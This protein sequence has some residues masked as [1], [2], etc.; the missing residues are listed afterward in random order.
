MKRFIIQSIGIGVLLSLFLVSCERNTQGPVDNSGASPAAALSKAGW[1]QD[2][3]AGVSV[4]ASG[5]NGPRGLKFGHDGYLYVSE[6]GLGGTASSIGCE[7]VIPPVGPYTNGPT[8]RICRISSTGEVS[9]VVDG[10][11]SG[12]NAMG[13]LLGV[14]DVAFIGNR[15]YGLLSG[16]GCSHGRADVPASVIRVG[17]NGDWSVVADLSTY[18]QGNPVAHPEED[19]FEPDGSWYSMITVGDDLFA[20]EPNHG[21]LVK[22]DPE[23]G[24]ITRVADISASQGHI[25][26]TVVVYH[27]GSFYV[28]NLN[29][30]PI[31]PGGS[32]IL[33]ISR[34]GNVEV[35]ATGFT[36]V[37]GL[38]F[39]RGGELYVLESTTSAGF[40]TPNT[41]RVVRVNKSGPNDVIADGLFFPTGMT[42]G[43]DGDLFVSNRGFGPPIPGFGEILR[44]GL[45]HGKGEGED[46]HGEDDEN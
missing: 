5:L 16:G 1:N 17:G 23:T 9:T 46:H 18:Q 7:Q 42:V 10:L 43:P 26:P 40:P 25:V 35:W 12:K 41:G 20:I 4:F 28:G 32:K 15:L 27:G 13:D 21:E 34:Q 31:A 8:A 30:F 37:L 38:A 39:G 3:P 2:S 29:T 44:I 6:A 19:D 33:R 22:I 11:P 24:K 45:L 14:N 36:T